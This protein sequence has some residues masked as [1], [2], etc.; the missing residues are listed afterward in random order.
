M[1]DVTGGDGFIVDPVIGSTKWRDDQTR[2]AHDLG[3]TLRTTLASLSYLADPF[4]AGG[5]AG[6][7]RGVPPEVRQPAAHAG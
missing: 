3:G 6:S 5:R 2:I 7:A 1:D 4:P